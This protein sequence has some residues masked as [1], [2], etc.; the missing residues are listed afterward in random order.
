MRFFFILFFVVNFSFASLSFNRNTTIYNHVLK[1]LDIPQKFI[2]TRNFHTIQ[3]EFKRYRKSHFFDVSRTETYFVPDLIKIINAQNIPDVFLFMALA[4]SGFAIHA[5]SRKKAI[6]LWQFMPATAK[7]FGLRVDEF[8]DERKD[9]Y[10]STNAAIK[11]LKHLHTIF[12]KWYLAALAYNCGEGRVLKAIKKAGTDDIVTLIDPKK[13]YLPKESR[14]YIYK[15][16]MLALMANDAR[17]QLN[18]DLA[19]ILLRGEEY[20]VIPVQVKGAELLGYISDSIRLNYNYLKELNPHLKRAFT[21]PDVQKYT[22]YIPR[23][24]YND[25]KRFYKP[26]NFAEGFL[27]HRVKKG[28]SLYK[29]ARKYGVKVSMLKRFNNLNRSMIRIGQKLIVPIPK[30]IIKKRVY[31]VKKGDTLTFIAKKFGVT[32]HKIKQWNKKRDSRLRIG[33]ALVIYN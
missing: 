10:K 2:Y 14:R 3:Q 22:I 26:S 16:V 7:K 20:D 8:V 6:G 30:K 32:A 13:R 28:E 11:Y 9:P 4:E 19:Y 15:I 29:I 1:S 33:E 27:T 17:Y 24:K 12:G 31:R 25:F 5:K 23:M 21:P 18:A